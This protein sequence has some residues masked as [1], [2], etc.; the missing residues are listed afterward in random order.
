MVDSE[1]SD[2]FSFLNQLWPDLYDLGRE[3]EQVAEHQPELAAIKLR[4]LT[5]AMVIKLCGHLEVQIEKHKSHFD[6]LVLLE[7]TSLFDRQLMSKFHA[8]RLVGNNA[9]HGKKVQGNRVKTLLEDAWSLSCWFFKFMRPDIELLISPKRLAKFSSEIP[10]AENQNG[11]LDVSP[12]ALTDAS[13]ILK[14]PEDRI[15]RIHAQVAK[16]MEVVDPS[17]WKPR[18]EI[19]LKEAFSESLS[20]DQESC[21][22]ALSAFLA[23]NKQQV[24]LLKGYAGTGKTFLAR[25]ITEYFSAQGRAFCLVA[26]TG[27]AAKILSEKT[28]RVA[29]TIHSQIYDFSDLKEYVIGDDKLGSETYKLFA[30]VRGNGD[31]TNSI[32]IVDEASLVSSEYSEDAFFR[33]GSGY[34]LKDLFEYLGVNKIGAARKIIF[35]GDPAQLPPVKMSFSPAMDSGH[36]GEAYSLTVSEYELTEVLRQK[37]DGGVIA[38]V[39]PLREGIS[40]NSFGSLHF[41][42]GEDVSRIG[43]DEILPLY[44]AARSGGGVGSP[45]V[46]TRTNAEAASVNSSI[47]SALF[48]GQEFV[49]SGDRLMV[50]SNTYVDGIFLANGEYVDVI[51]A[52]TMVERRSVTLRWKDVNTGE[53]NQGEVALVFRDVR[54]STTLLD[55]DKVTLTVKIL[56]SHLHGSGGITHEE[57]RALYVDF[58]KRHPWVERNHDRRD[59][60]LALRSD[61]YF[62]ALRV[63]FGYAITCHK[64]QGGEWDHVFVSC[65]TGM[66]PRTSEYFRW[67]YTAMT[68]SSRWLYLINPPEIRITV[69]GHDGLPSSGGEMEAFDQSNSQVELTVNS[70]PLS[71]LESFRQGVLSR[72]RGL[73]D[74]SGIEIADVAHHQYQEAFFFSRDQDS[75]RVNVSYNGKFKVTAVAIP[76]PGAFGSQLSGLLRPMVGQS[77]Y[78]M[79]PPTEGDASPKIQAPSR[80]F[81]ARFHDRLLMAVG[82]RG[83]Q[84]VGL[85]EQEWSQRYTFARADDSVDVDVYFDGKER[86]TKCMPIKSRAGCGDLSGT[87]LPDVLD[88]I[89]AHVVL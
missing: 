76:V 89:T 5:E 68:R 77:F 38:N 22:Q 18:T 59:L 87:L 56:D 37:A 60:L 23:D 54:L 44:M 3:A 63:K 9:A 24:F 2:S 30:P 1:H 85:K 75:V 79:A 73:I 29:R 10:S 65:P 83:I 48:P 43:V 16:A 31:P 71:Q 39:M 81:L 42:F 20:T 62:T 14:F 28:G 58:L 32:F 78:S 88:A 41:K 46:I 74:G 64:A 55:G 61:P 25:G 7:K 50:A 49:S 13:K 35:I 82:G 40:S 67:L 36:L 11:V 57:Q 47:R 80:A 45:I 6:R 17:S 84:V 33:A 26:P 66:N 52:G 12:A 34:L 19:T 15:R 72:V 53:I 69:V 21:L 8:I 27:R 51:D 70:A 86:I 4:S